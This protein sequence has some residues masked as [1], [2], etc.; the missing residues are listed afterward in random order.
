MMARMRCLLLLGLFLRVAVCSVSNTTQCDKD[1]FKHEHLCC[2]YC[3]AGTYLINPCQKNHGT[4]ECAP[5]DSKHFIDHKNREP[6]C[7]PCSVCRDDQEEVATC[8]S[9]TDRKCQCKQGTYCDSENCLEKCHT[10]S[11]CPDSK[12]IRK[13]N[14]TT[15]TVCDTFDSKPVL[16]GHPHFCFPESLNNVVITAAVIT[17]IA[18]VIAVIAAVI[19][20]IRKIICHYRK[21]DKG[22]QN[23]VTGVNSASTEL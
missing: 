9:T 22:A 23:S 14:A 6:E 8:S 10:C 11:S 18:A 1:E 19:T 2:Q 4:S 7:F 20:V 16:S 5:C 12:V 3:S 13:C 15:D 17:V 21:K